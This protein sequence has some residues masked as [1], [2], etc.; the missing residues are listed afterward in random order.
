MIVNYT[1]AILLHGVNHTR[2]LIHADGAGM[3]GPAEA[4][5]GGGN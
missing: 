2:L 4:E 1:Y 3:S 5:A